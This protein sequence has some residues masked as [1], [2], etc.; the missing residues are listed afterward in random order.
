MSDR[1][2]SVGTSLEEMDKLKKKKPDKNESV[3]KT[4]EETNKSN[5]NMSAIDMQTDE[6]VKNLFYSV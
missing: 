5:G 3:Q 6:E 2:N 1:S 4:V